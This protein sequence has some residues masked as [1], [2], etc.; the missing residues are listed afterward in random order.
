[1]LKKIPPQNFGPVGHKHGLIK[2]AAQDVPFMDSLTV[3]QITVYIYHYGM[4]S[5]FKEIL[6]IASITAQT[7]VPNELV[8][9]RLFNIAKML[10]IHCH[11]IVVTVPK[12]LKPTTA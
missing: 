12:D 3:L 11:F 8:P 4:T 2:N 10:M 6:K 5:P 1:M 7:A 9:K